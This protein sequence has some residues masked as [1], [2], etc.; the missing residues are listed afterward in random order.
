MATTN[1]QSCGMPLAR[2]P[3]GGGTNA[4][5]SKNSE[6]CSNCYQNGSYTEPDL[7]MNQMLTKVKGKL[8]EMHFPGLMIN[9]MTRDIANLKRWSGK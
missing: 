7:T 3:K 4:D 2:D 1:C 5:G 6:F 8:K 9:M